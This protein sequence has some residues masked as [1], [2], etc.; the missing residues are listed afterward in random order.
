MS[1][2]GSVSR[3]FFP[4]LGGPVVAGCHVA[5]V[6]GSFLGLSLCSQRRALSVVLLVIRCLAV[7]PGVERSE[8]VLALWFLIGDLLFLHL[9]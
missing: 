7:L 1:A 9:F 2:R 5:E 8:K 3:T 6:G 4:R